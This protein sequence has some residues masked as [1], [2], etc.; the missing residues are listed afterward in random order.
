MRNSMRMLTLGPAVALALTAG[1]AMAGNQDRP[2]PTAMPMSLL[3]QAIENSITNLAAFKE[4]S[5]DDDGYWEVE[6]WT[7]D[8]KTVEGRVDPVTGTVTV[9]R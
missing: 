6:M 4:I 5:W 8:G 2:P 9:G 7:T 1:A 3:T